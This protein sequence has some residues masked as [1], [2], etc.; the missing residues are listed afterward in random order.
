MEQNSGEFVVKLC[1]IFYFLQTGNRKMQVL[2]KG[3][4]LA[5]NK[6][7]SFSAANWKYGYP[8]IYAFGNG[9]QLMPLFRPF[10]LTQMI[11]DSTEEAAGFFETEMIYKAIFCCETSNFFLA[12]YASLK[13]CKSALWRR[14]VVL[15]TLSNFGTL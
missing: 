5:R 3:W 10:Q 4:Q 11:A 6:V 8:I 9:L 13:V 12:F 1:K 15:N 2:N 14:Q 7:S